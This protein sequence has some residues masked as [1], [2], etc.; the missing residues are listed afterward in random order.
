M[1]PIAGLDGCGK[2]H[3]TRIRS[4]DR[5]D[6]IVSLYRLR[7]PGTSLILKNC[8]VF[9]KIVF[10]FRIKTATFPLQNFDSLVFKVERRSVV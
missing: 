8:A 9:P 7:S 2:P 5:P 1:G 3:H 10:M 6:H 4:A